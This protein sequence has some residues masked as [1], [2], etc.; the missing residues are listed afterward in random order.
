M[1]KY[2]NQKMIDVADWDALV[3][4]TYG[5][6]YYAFQQQRGCREKGTYYIEVPSDFT[7]DVKY[8]NSIPEKVNGDVMGVKFQTWLDRDP[9]YMGSFT[10]N[11][12]NRLFWERN[13]YP[14]IHTLANDLYKKGLIE[15]GEYLID[16]DW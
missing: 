1:L 8:P 13:F 16:I 11:F 7:L 12:E 4:E 10:K 2:T 3:K 5:K 9:G 15:E 14:D 6:S